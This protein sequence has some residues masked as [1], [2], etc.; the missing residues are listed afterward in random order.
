MAGRRHLFPS[1]Q[2][3]V[4]LKVSVH[5]HKALFQLADAL[6]DAAR[7]D[8][9][10]QLDKGM[11]QAGDVVAEEVR[12][13]TDSYMPKGYEQVWAGALKVKT[14]SSLI[15][16]RRVS[17]VGRGVGEEGND[18]QAS[19][20]E[21]GR[22]KR[23]VYGR[24]RMLKNGTRMANQWVWQNIRPHWFTEPAKRA[25]PAAVSKIDDAFGRVASKIEGAI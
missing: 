4:T 2:L 5:G 13:H 24:Y 23:P 12:E 7:K 6:H 18:R 17:V 1:N 21:A 9:S 20:L 19:E 22:F 10:R 11:R 3:T 8:L 15:R 25:A 14:E 16:A